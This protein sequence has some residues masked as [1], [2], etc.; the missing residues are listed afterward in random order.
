M[1]VRR[2]LLTM[3]RERTMEI[4]ARVAKLTMTSHHQ[5]INS[6][7]RKGTS[8]HREMAQHREMMMTTLTTQ[9]FQ[10]HHILSNTDNLKNL[11]FKAL[12]AI[13]LTGVKWRG[14]QG[15]RE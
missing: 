3:T 13:I 9:S 10:D 1:V 14:S 12:Q 7:V 5:N 11:N 8:G 6:V 4:N 15:A 2:T